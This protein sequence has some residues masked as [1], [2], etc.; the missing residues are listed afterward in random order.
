MVHMWWGWGRRRGRARQAVSRFAPTAQAA[1]PSH[2][3]P[4]LH[5]LLALAF[6]PGYNPPPD[7]E[8][9]SYSVLGTTAGKVFGIF[10]ALGTIAFGFG[11]TILP[12]IQVR[13]SFPPLH[14]PPSLPPS[15]PASLPASLP[16]GTR[17]R[18]CHAAAA[19]PPRAGTVLLLQPACA[20]GPLSVCYTRGLRCCHFSWKH[21]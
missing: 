11:D 1:S 5:S 9:V 17:P 10:S 13:P 14:L 12:E 8:P 3:P 7:A 18:S 21:G 4:S 6:P 19:L 2:P 16:L 15:L 20:V